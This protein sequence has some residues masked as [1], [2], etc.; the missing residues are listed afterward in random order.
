MISASARQDQRPSRRNRA[1][2]APVCQFHDFAPRF[3][4]AF[5]AVSPDSS[6]C[7]RNNPT[8]RRQLSTR[9]QQIR[10]T[11]QRVEL[12]GVLLDPAIPHLAMAEQV[13][14]HM[15][16]MFDKL[17]LCQASCRVH[18]IGNQSDRGW[19]VSEECPDTVRGSESVL[20]R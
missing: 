20:C 14:D 10:Q 15:E 7:R 16:R 12:G 13:L 4:L 11:K 18:F 6:R 3:Q 5:R 17:P 9:E 19:Q 1:I 8:R 2:T